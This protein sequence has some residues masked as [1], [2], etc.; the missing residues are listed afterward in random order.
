[1]KPLEHYLELPYAI[2]LQKDYDAGYVGLIADLPGC[3]ARGSTPQ[4]TLTALNEAKRIWLLKRLQSGEQ[5]PEPTDPR[6]LPS[7]RWLQRVPRTLHK[8]LANLAE[9][10]GV[11]L[12][13]LV[14]SILSEALGIR[15]HL[16][17]APRYETGR[18]LWALMSNWTQAYE[19]FSRRHPDN[20]YHSPA[21]VQQN[22]RFVQML[23]HILSLGPHSNEILTIRD[24]DDDRIEDAHDRIRG[25]LR[26]LP[27]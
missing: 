27:S 5:I 17:P 6:H 23:D 10:E 11:S 26:R 1:M 16:R 22:P 13:Q 12:N 2:T 15:E 9:R 24:T 14:T 19:R 4:E 7:G 8:R 21:R 25:Y 20:W 3:S 18:R